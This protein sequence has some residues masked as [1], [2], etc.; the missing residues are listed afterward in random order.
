MSG[1]SR[2]TCRRQNGQM[3]RRSLNLLERGP[4]FIEEAL[5]HPAQLA[6]CK[7]IRDLIVHL[8]TLPTPRAELTAP[9]PY[10]EFQRLLFSHLIDVER[11]QAEATRNVKRERARKTV[12]AAPRGSWELEQV[13]FDR[14]A[15]QLRSVGDALAWRL[16]RFDRRVIFALSRTQ[17]T[18]PMYGKA[19]LERELEELQTIWQNE[20]A[21][22]L[23]H[24]VTS[25]M[26]IA[27]LTKFV[28]GR[29]LLVEVKAKR[30]GPTTPQMKR[31]QEAIDVVNTGAPLRGED[32]KL[33]NLFMATQ[34][35]KTHLGQLRTALERADADGMS[36]A[37]LGQHWVVTCFSLTSPSLPPDEEGLE[38]FLAMRARALKKADMEG[39]GQHHL[40]GVRPD[41]IGRDPGLAPFSIYP[42][43]PDVCAR[44][45]CELLHYES[46]M[47]WERLAAAF[48]ALGFQT[49]CPLPETSD[50]T[51]GSAPVLHASRGSAGMTIH[52][53]GITQILYELID[54]NTWAA[55][56]TEALKLWP[57]EAPASG[58][59]TFANERS[60]WR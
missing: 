50:R 60:V 17:P 25:C 23:L 3:A 13:V 30:T 19:G 38:Q 31:M 32:G 41:A 27:D 37:R 39:Q 11:R 48:E 10:Y 4:D 47:R 26:R 24:G 21:F 40:R 14:I 5:T 44:L 1:P 34:P 35:F 36:A 52:G 58:V 46:V 29:A 28:D 59:F 9:E 20:R 56:A 51:P 12:P 2:V 53:S 33:S 49:E 54:P 42:F 6:A 45:T 7:V 55:A 18:G 15:R 8:R 57:G 43:S 16:H 22:P